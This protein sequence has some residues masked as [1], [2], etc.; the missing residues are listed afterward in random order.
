MVLSLSPSDLAVCSLCTDT[1]DTSA[2][3][4]SS[5]PKGQRVLPHSNSSTGAL[6]LWTRTAV[7][8]HRDTGLSAPACARSFRSSASWDLRCWFG[9][10]RGWGGRLLLALLPL[11]HQLAENARRRAEA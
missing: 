11:R 2:S 4:T 3:M 9:R 8:A 5:Y 1:S 10:T 6:G 7:A